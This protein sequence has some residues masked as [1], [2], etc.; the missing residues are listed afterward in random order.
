[1]ASILPYIRSATL[2][3]AVGGLRSGYSSTG[4]PL[5]SAEIDR[6]VASSTA[7]IRRWSFYGVLYGRGLNSPAGRVLTSD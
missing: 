1:M 7:R 5:T 4:R 3:L 6:A 2:D